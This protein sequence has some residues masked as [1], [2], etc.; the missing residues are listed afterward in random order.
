MEQV[1]KR[2]IKAGRHFKR[3]G[4]AIRMAC[5]LSAAMLTMTLLKAFIEL[6]SALLTLLR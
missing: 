1:G 4:S 6:L 2:A 3:R 5:L